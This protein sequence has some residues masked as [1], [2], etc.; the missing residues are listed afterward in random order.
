M[1]HDE[2]VKDLKE[3][4]EQLAAEVQTYHDAADLY[5]IDPM[6]MLTLAKSQI[7]TCA[8]NIRLIQKMECVLDIFKWVPNDLTVGE[9]CKAIIHYDGD[10]SKPYCNL[11]Y[12]GLDIIRKYLEIRD[13]LNKWKDIDL[14]ISKKDGSI[15]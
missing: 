6:T 9:V 14:S 1:E 3:K 2:T 5:G 10:G 7:E 13:E 15:K 8:D 4:C 11:V 12:C